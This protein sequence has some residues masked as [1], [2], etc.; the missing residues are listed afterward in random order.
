MPRNPRKKDWQATLEPDQLHYGSS[1]DFKRML[2]SAYPELV[3]PES[4]IVYLGEGIPGWGPG[5]EETPTMSAVDGRRNACPVCRDDKIHRGSLICCP[6]C[7]RSGFEGKLHEQRRLA[8][9]PAP[10]RVAPDP[11]P[12]PPLAPNSRPAQPGTRKARHW[13]NFAW[14]QD[15]PARPAKP[16]PAPPSPGQPPSGPEPSRDPLP[17]SSAA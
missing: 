6:R 11:Q 2:R 8:G 15:P 7:H 5:R 12:A 10:A 14:S 17:E 3:V 1:E 13:S 4:E 9:Y 16:H